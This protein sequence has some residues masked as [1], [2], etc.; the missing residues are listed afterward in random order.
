MLDRLSR[1]QFFKITGGFVTGVTAAGSAPLIETLRANAANQAG[2]KV[3]GYFENWSQYRPGGGKFLPE[4]IDASL[5][6]HINFAFGIFGFVTKSVNP[7]NPRLT[8]NYR[9]EPVE[10]N[11]Q[12]VLYPAI[13]KLKQ[14]N[15]N[16]KTLLSIGGWSFN[17]P[18]DP[19]K[20][21]TYT[22]NLFSQMAATSAGRQ[23]FISSAIEYARKYGFDGIDLDWEYPGY[24]GRGG[25]PEDIPNFLKLVQEFRSAISGKNLLLTMASPAI[26]PSGVPAQYHS[27]PQSYFKWLAQCAQYFDWLNVMSYDYHGAFPDDKV[28]GMNAPLPQD[29]TPNGKF[30]VKN[31][32]E[33]YLNAGIP[34]SKIVLGLPSYGRSFKVSS[35]LSLA[36]NGPGKAYSSAGP[37][38]VATGIPGILAYYEIAD[39]IAT[40]DLKRQWHES[41]LTPYAYKSQNGEWISY[42][43]AES[44]GY[45]TSYL[46]EQGLAGAMYWAI[47][48][49]K[50]QTGFPLIKRTKSILAN[51]SSRPKL[52][53][54][55][56]KIPKGP[57]S[58]IDKLS[59]SKKIS[60]VNIPGTH[61]TCALH[62]AP[63]NLFGAICQNR[64]LKEQLEA[65]IRFID[66]RCRHIENVFAIHHGAI[67]QKI[68]FGTG[69]RDVCINFL[70]A[71]PSEFIIMSIKRE[72]NDANNTR[73]FQDTFDWYIKGNENFWFFDN[74]IP[75]IKEVRGKIV[76]LR[77]FTGNKG[78]AALPWADNATFDVVKNG[79]TLKIQDE[80]TVNTILAPDI[81]KK[82]EKIKNLLDKAKSDASDNWYINFTSGA[83]TGAYP[84]AVAGR[85]NYRVYD[86]LGAGNFSNR[87]GTFAMDFPDNNMIN[88]IISLNK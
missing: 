68:N 42:D 67:Y 38:G 44:I 47:G 22:S 45:K 74:R 18:Q 9:I 5:F 27:N 31:T 6:T 66:I 51:P 72:Y 10:W 62:G 53:A 56:V 4:Q 16:L 29:S 55:L 78:I 83:S 26:V 28:T 63:L 20:I 48:L 46:I 13:Q 58:W 2:Y 54:S 81:N 33:A 73:E 21:G 39:R 64:T 50:F 82:W 41:T 49:D 8:G 3:V 35:P 86:Y 37:A 88:R 80:Y 43:D 79:G 70:K 76:L 19:N 25:K 77:R 59:D 32:V 85:I 36:S 57:H 52:P 17:D 23:Q 12:T 15:P 30:S 40:G 69:V 7:S 14:K 60:K 24:S 75:T 61:E 11:D 87:L 71:N 65:G 34:T 1:R 84:D